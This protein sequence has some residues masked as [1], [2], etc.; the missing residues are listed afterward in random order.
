MIFQLMLD[1]SDGSV[2]E[3]V[4]VG[5]Y[6][7]GGKTDLPVIFN[8]VLLIELIEWPCF[9]HVALRVSFSVFIVYI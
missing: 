2:R 7:T 1:D 6:A 3:T 9:V 5:L 8:T 4:Y